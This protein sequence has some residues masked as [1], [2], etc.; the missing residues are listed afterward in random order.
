MA[1]WNSDEW[2]E[3]NE[4]KYGYVFGKR[5]IFYQMKQKEDERA[6]RLN[7]LKPQRRHRFINVDT[8]GI[9]GIGSGGVF[10]FFS[11]AVAQG[12]RQVLHSTGERN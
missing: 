6:E 7:L 9:N 11:K 4:K 2:E 10:R 1:D 5:S 3:C 12:A 8:G